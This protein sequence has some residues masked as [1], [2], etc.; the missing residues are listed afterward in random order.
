M[1]YTSKEL[2]TNNEKENLNF[3]L[4]V[5][6]PFHTTGHYLYPLKTL[7]S[8]R[9]SDFFRGHRQSPQAWN[10]SRTFANYSPGFLPRRSN[11]ILV[12]GGNCSVNF[13]WVLHLMSS[14]TRVA[15][16]NLLGIFGSKLKVS[17]T[18]SGHSRPHLHVPS[19]SK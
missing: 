12:V 16:L 4:N 18:F 11:F 15:G 5:V 8:Q 3:H 7:E 14:L 19:S 2:K 10:G 9:F 13:W 17:S 6:N 1:P